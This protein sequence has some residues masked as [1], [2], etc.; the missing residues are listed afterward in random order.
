MSTSTATS[1][2]IFNAHHRTARA[3]AAKAHDVLLASTPTAAEV[4]ILKEIRAC[5]AV[6]A[7]TRDVCRIDVYSPSFQSVMEQ[8]NDR[9][10]SELPVLFRLL[11]KVAL[12]PRGLSDQV[13]ASV[14]FHLLADALAA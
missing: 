14:D 12:P 7:D 5:R 3:A 10:A 1:P 13:L 8:L 2:S 9:A 4:V 6:L 11:M